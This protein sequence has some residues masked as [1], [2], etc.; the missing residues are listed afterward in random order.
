MNPLVSINIATY[1]SE[2]TLTKCLDSIK[3]QTYKNIEIIIMDSYSKDNTLAI[4]RAFGAKIFFA[5][6]LALARKVEQMQVTA[7]MYFY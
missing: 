5:P 1:N 7:N 4:S 6:S 3:C 2:K